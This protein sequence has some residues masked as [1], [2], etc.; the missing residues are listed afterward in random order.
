[1]NKETSEILKNYSEIITHQIHGSHLVETNTW[2]KPPIY[3]EKIVGQYVVGVPIKEYTSEPMH[4]KEI[5]L[6][7]ET[8]NFWT[9][10]EVVDEVED[11]E[12]RKE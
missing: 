6:P 3:F 4:G 2:A 9:Y 1:M 7:G 11:L 5:I 8:N 12:W 10:Y